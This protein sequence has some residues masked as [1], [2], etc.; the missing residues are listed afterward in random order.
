MPSQRSLLK[1][2]LASL[3]ISATKCDKPT[4]GPIYRWVKKWHIR[5]LSKEIASSWF[6]FFIFSYYAPHPTTTEATSTTTIPP[7]PP[8]PYDPYFDSYYSPYAAPSGPSAASNYDGGLYYYYPAE[9]P[10][11]TTTVAEETT[12]AAASIF[13]SLNVPLLR[14]AAI[15]FFLSIG[16]PNTLNI[17]SV[18]RKRSGRVEFFWA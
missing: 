8:A 15:V 16:L 6:F 1:V 14:I 18:R 9:A 2:L 5:I 3:A 4:E 10:V 13:D 17:T 7:P 11:E 12:T